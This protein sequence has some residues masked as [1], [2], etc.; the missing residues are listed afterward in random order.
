MSQTSQAQNDVSEHSVEPPRLDVADM[1]KYFGSVVALDEVSLTLESGSFHALLG[2]NGAGKSTLVKCIMGYHHPDKG[3]VLI[4]KVVHTVQSPHDAHMLGVGMVYQHFTLIPN[5]TVAENLLLSR[6]DI[7]PIVRWADE[8][9]DMEA[10]VES[11]PFRV[12]LA[13]PISTL[14][15]GEKQKLEI[16]KQ[17]YLKCRI[18]ILDEPTSVLTPAEADEIL[19]FLRKMTD[20]GQLSVLMITHK[21]REVG[22][23]AKEVTV[24]RHGRVS[25]RGQT[26]DLTPADLTHMMVGDS[27]I[28][29][30]AERMGH[31]YG[32][33]RLRLDGLCADNDKGHRALGNVSLEVHSG[34]IV[35]I[36]GVSGNGQQELVEV[37]AGQRDRSGGVITVHGK[38]YLAIRSQMRRHRV[39]CLPEEPLRN[40]CVPRMR[41]SEN[42]AFRNFDQPPFLTGKWFLNRNAIRRAA[43][44]LIDQFGIK[45]P[46]ADLPAY[47][48]S[49][50]NIQRMVL[51]RE[52][53][54]DVDILVVANPCFG[55]DIA[56]IAEIRSRIMQVRNKGGAILLVSEDLDELFEL[57]DR[58][59]VMLN[60]AVHYEVAIAEANRATIGRYMVSQV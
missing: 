20:A 11:T 26:K 29:K 43:D 17:L 45:T 18:L 2:E 33:V 55:L 59:L 19:G 4:N 10:F 36:A 30:Q 56:A 16:L 28:A 49:G 31:S 7:P 22:E 50:G 27:P 54:G 25:G 57:S 9:R 44:S 8:R 40:A 47:T 32:Q 42:L 60:G 1:C 5:M 39:F 48:L 41:I 34:E 53:S 58:I 23:Y 21:L 24:L 37:L 14:S 13:A 3:A 12:D 46:S 6:A 51:A 38:P 35:G 15:A 52:L